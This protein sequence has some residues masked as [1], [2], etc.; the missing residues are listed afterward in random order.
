MAQTPG[1]RPSPPLDLLQVFD[2]R[3]SSVHCR[4]L[5]VLLLHT[6]PSRTSDTWSCTS[7]GLPIRVLSPMPLSTFPFPSARFPVLS[8]SFDRRI[9]DVHTN[10]ATPPEAPPRTTA[11]VAKGMSPS[12]LLVR[13]PIRSVPRR[14]RGPIGSRS[15]P[16][17]R[18]RD[19][20]PFSS[21]SFLR[22]LDG[23]REVHSPRGL[24]IAQI[25][26]TRSCEAASQHDDGGFQVRRTCER[27]KE[28]APRSEHERIVTWNG[29][30]TAK[31]RS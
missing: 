23:E 22:D 26:W 19:L 29:T 7:L 9:S 17:P 28:G 8:S 15:N 16:P 12:S 24:Q 18:H 20:V 3:I 6:C 25:Q 21:T 10:P 13:T 30:W 27:E 31:E 2:L 14:G 5:G 1:R 11:S 4:F